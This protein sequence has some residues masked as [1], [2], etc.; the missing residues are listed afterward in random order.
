VSEMGQTL[1]GN[2]KKKKEIA[3]TL[4]EYARLV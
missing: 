2:E 3:G 1:S 4:P